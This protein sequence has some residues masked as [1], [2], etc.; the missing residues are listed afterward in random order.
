MENNTS[1]TEPRITAEHT[2]S[3]TSDNATSLNDLRSKEGANQLV[4]PR[5]SAET[6][7]ALKDAQAS[8][9][10]LPDELILDIFSHLS[11]NFLQQVLRTSKRYKEIAYSVVY[12]R[13]KEGEPEK[14]RNIANH[15][16]LD[17]YTKVINIRPHGGP[18]KYME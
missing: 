11:Q 2:T 3:T 8:L 16:E 7:V 5:T 9:D 12:C 6:F 15:P 18:D 13:I 10:G 14:L 1:G 17:K 4:E